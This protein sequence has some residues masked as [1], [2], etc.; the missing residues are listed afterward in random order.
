MGLIKKM[1]E[2]AIERG[3]AYSKDYDYAAQY[4]LQGAI[5]AKEMIRNSHWHENLPD[6]WSQALADAQH[7]NEAGNLPLWIQ[8]ELDLWENQHGLGGDCDI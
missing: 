5:R 4:D 7:E 8:L 2:D 3:Y 1:L 6:L